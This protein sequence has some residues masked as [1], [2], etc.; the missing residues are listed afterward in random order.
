MACLASPT[1][2]LSKPLANVFSTSGNKLFHCNTDVSWNSSINKCSYFSP[3][4][5]YKNGTGSVSTIAAM[6]RLNSEI[7]TTFRSRLIFST[8]LFNSLNSEA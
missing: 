4:R 8:N 2:K 7:S 3:S 1:A 5:S 6:R